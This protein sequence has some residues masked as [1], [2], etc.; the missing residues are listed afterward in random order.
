MT[1]CPLVVEQTSQAVRST[2]FPSSNPCRQHTQVCISDWSKV[3]PPDTHPPL[4]QSSSTQTD[5]PQHLSITVLLVIS[6]CLRNEPHHPLIG[7][8]S[9]LLRTKNLPGETRR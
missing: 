4:F 1:E 6:S 3:H 9:H 2:P 8:K 5:P 7:W